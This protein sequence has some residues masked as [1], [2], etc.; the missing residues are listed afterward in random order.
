MVGRQGNKR[1]VETFLVATGDQ[2]LSNTANA[3]EHLINQSTGIPRLASGQLGIIDYSGYGSNTF[4]DFT[5][6]NPTVAE[7]PVIQI[8]QGNA[9]SATLTTA[10]ATYPLWPRP[11]EAS[12]PINGNNP[13]VITKQAPT[14]GTSSVWVI[15]QPDGTTGEIVS[16][17]NTNYSMRIA[18]RGRIQDEMYSVESAA[19]F[20]PHYT[21][22]DYSATAIST[23]ALRRDHLIQNLVWDI[24]RNSTAIATNRTRFRGNELIVALAI[25]STGAAGDNIGGKG[26]GAT[27]IAAGDY[28]PV[29]STTAGTRGITLTADQA[30]SIKNAAVSAS[31]DAI[32][33]V[34]WSILTVDLTTA[35]TATGG[36]ADV[37][38]LLALDRNEVYKD[39][40]PQKK[41]R[42]DVGLISG[43]DFATV[44]HAQHEEAKEPL[45]DGR[46]LALL[47]D[48]THGQRK[49]NLQHVEDP[50]VNF[51]NPVD[52]SL[53]Y[54][55]YII[56]HADVNSID[57]FNNSVSPMREYILIPSAG[58][59]TVT[60]FDTALNAWLG[61]INSA[62]VSI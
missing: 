59:T 6:V 13:V 8:V 38:M 23:A 40:V 11:Y 3:G 25:D 15:G 46:K 42:L 21:T 14:T 58:T 9:N 36:V 31:G 33:D 55:T 60:A 32:A 24:N 19:H 45:G 41:T 47:Y 27:H 34:T 54:Y 43:F 26:S 7:S 56:E 28:I 39:Y 53:S 35:G 22:P 37:I 44:S 49:Y 30:N 29:V 48:S 5:D 1:A 4:M 52:T 57:T 51:A 16:V 62:I 20:T 18:F 50:I 17:S 10:T 12:A 2:A 61:S